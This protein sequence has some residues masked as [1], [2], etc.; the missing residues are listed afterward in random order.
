[1]E[2]SGMGLLL[3]ITIACTI[4]SSCFAQP[5]SFP[6]RAEMRRNFFNEEEGQSLTA[7]FDALIDSF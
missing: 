6:G 2:Q 4:V 7:R 3:G 5:E 1:M